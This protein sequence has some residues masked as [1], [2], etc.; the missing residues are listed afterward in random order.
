MDLKPFF[1]K[2]E[3]LVRQVDAAF[4]KVKGEYEACVRC[5]IGCSDCCHALFD[6]TLIEALYIKTQFDSLFAGP[7]REEVLE[8]A[9]EAD[10]TIYRLKKR[11]FRDHEN[12]K[13]ERE[14]LEEMA[15][16]R[17]RCPALNSDDRCA[18][19]EVRPLT[20]RIYGI[21]TIIAGRSHTCGISGFQEGAAYPA[22]KLDA[23]FQK[24]YDISFELAQ[25]VESRYPKLAE[26]LVPLSMAMLT[27][28][29]EE[30]LGA[31]RNQEPA[32]ENKGE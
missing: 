8:R 19:Y 23:V 11:A 24:L 1:R 31:N 20:C 4:E 21:P 12:G 15:S 2:Y 18:I 28:Y 9:N 32:E 6:L 16:Q 25:A 14:I 27:D 30:Y 22:V 5:K 10:R 29:T 17:I 13:S 3:A 26:M 7:A